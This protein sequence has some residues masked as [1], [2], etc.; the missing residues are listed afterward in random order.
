MA[1]SPPGDVFVGDNL[2]DEDIAFCKDQ[3]GYT[4]RF[5]RGGAVYERWPKIVRP[6][7]T[8]VWSYQVENASEMI[9]VGATAG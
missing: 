3:F 4:Y 7:W 5:L 2:A 8:A 1:G 6:E 9:A